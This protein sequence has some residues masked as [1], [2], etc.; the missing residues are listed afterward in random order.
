[1]PWGLT[2]FHRGGQ[3]QF[4]TF[5]CYRR[6]RLLTSDVSCR[7]F[8]SALE[9]VRRTPLESKIAL[10]SAT[11]PRL[12]PQKRG[13]NLGHQPGPPARIWATGIDS[14]LLSSWAA[15]ELRVIFVAFNAECGF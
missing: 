6:H 3:S 11:R 8:E 7:V 1:M 4:V 5:S 12:A 13:A 2:R 10:E 14:S 9:R 15:H